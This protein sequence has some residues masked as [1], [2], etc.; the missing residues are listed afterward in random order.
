MMKWF[1]TAI[2]TACLLIAG[3]SGNKEPAKADS[4]LPELHLNNTVA[5]FCNLYAPGAVAVEGYGIVAGLGTNG[6]SEC[7]TQIREYMIKLVQQMLGDTNRLEAIRFI[8]S[9]DNAVVRVYGQ[10]PAG[11][12]RGQKFD[13]FVEALTNTQTT[14][15][16]DGSLF[17]CNLTTKSK[18]GVAGAKII[19]SG[20]GPMYVEQTEN[21][22]DLRKG[23]VIGGGSF[24]EDNKLYLELKKPD[25]RL[26]SII[27]NRINERFGEGTAAARSSHIVNLTIPKSFEG[28]YEKFG[29]LVT[30]LYLPEDNEA[31]IARTLLLARN[32][33]D[34]IDDSIEYGLEAIGRPALTAITPLLDSD[35]AAVR[36]RAARC[37]LN[38]GYEKAGDVLVELA[39]TPGSPYK[40]EAIEAIGESVASISTKSQLRQFLSDDD[41]EIKILCY[42]YLSEASDLSVMPKRTNSGFRIDTII[43]SK[44]PLVYVRRERSPRIVLFGMRIPL[45]GNIFI[46]LDGGNILVNNPVGSENILLLRQHPGM[47]EVIGPVYS[48][49]TV[50]DLVDKLSDNSVL[51]GG[52]RAG[53]GLGFTDTVRILRKLKEMQCIKAEVVI[54]PAPIRPE[55]ENTLEKLSD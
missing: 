29:K 8:N 14:S 11:A 21:P 1:L 20:Q 34:P 19:A 55:F 17:T 37:A 13:L 51:P 41:A 44:E 39:S 49:M 23:V 35:I 10:I 50:D 33:E 45:A 16:K 12:K 7:P 43:T 38:I 5:A 36:L 24:T 9:T 46:S 42:E 3:C 54:G 28:K 6:S 25:Y 40:R 18:L 26:T 22:Q 27:R 48:K 52:A 4:E 31:L 47:K 32:L 15:L 30:A 2:I 53:L